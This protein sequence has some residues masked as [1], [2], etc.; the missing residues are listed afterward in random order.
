MSVWV[1]W[2]I[3]KNQWCKQNSDDRY[4]MYCIIR[5]VCG[6]ISIGSFASLHNEYVVQ[7]RTQCPLS[8]TVSFIIEPEN[9]GIICLVREL[10]YIRRNV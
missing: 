6:I 1:I 4:E 3:Y 8:Y 7:N 2:G 9:Q 5:L 10:L